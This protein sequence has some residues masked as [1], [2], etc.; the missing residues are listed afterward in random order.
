[1]FN[2]KEIAERALLHAEIIKDG[3]AVKKRRFCFAAASA[4]SL[5][6]IVG[7]SFVITSTPV[8]AVSTP[9][10][11]SAALLAGGSNGGY[12]LIGV[13]G[14]ALG[15]AITAAYVKKARKD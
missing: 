3:R 12:A 14:F 13:V 15:A 10:N 7:L 1:M 6:L 11:A 2:A 5:A 4:A 9:D 8:A